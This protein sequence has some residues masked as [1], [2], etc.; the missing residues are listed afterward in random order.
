LLQD[1]SESSFNKLMSARKAIIRPM[2]L[3][4]LVAG[5]TA[6]T[7][8]T[9]TSAPEQSA[10]EQQDTCG[11]KHTTAEHLTCCVTFDGASDLP[12]IEV[13][14]NLQAQGRRQLCIAREPQ[15]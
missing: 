5:A 11:G 7:W 3:A 10:P 15:N 6:Q 2:L 13:E 12:R 9:G 1:L 14:F 8:R 4:V